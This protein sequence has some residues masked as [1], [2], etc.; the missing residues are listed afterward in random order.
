MTQGFNR[1]LPPR[2]RD[3]LTV[4]EATFFVEHF[5]ERSTQCMSILEHVPLTPTR[6]G[7]SHRRRTVIP[8]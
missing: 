1:P 3:F 2:R 6:G 8:S 4:R 5:G 7:D